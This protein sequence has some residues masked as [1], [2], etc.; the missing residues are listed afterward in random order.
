MERFTSFDFGLTGLA[1]LFHQDWAHLGSVE[2]VAFAHLSVGQELVASRPLQQEAAALEHDVAV[3]I[4]SPLGDSQIELLWT[5]ATGGNY[6]FNASESGRH[7]LWRVG[8][9]CRQWQQSYGG[10]PVDVDPLWSTSSV[11]SRVCDAIAAASFSFPDRGRSEAQQSDVKRLRQSL[12]SCARSA[13]PELA[14][15][16]LLRIY[17]SNFLPVDRSSWARY[18]RLAADFSFGEYL[19]SG[20]D[21]LVDD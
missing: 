20:L 1:A 12:D 9:A 2:E 4:D 8:A 16:L 17:L 11:T 18:Q 6:R 14:F 3:L 21:F 10:L 19:L 15:R 5:M 7:F 13:S